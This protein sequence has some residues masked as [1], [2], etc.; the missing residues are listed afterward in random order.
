MGLKLVFKHVWVWSS[1]SRPALSEVL[2][3]NQSP[4]KSLLTISTGENCGQVPNCRIA[5]NPWRV[6]I[7]KIKAAIVPQT[8]VI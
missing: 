8:E 5:F 4:A 6:A 1:S 2:I 3:A 7:L